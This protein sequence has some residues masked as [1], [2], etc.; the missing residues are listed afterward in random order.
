MRLDG[1]IDSARSKVRE[2]APSAIVGDLA[3]YI[4]IDVREPEEVL[5]GY[6]PD[7]INVPRGVLER[8]VFED[9][10]FADQFQPVLLYS[11]NGVRSLLACLTLQQIGFQN[12]QSLAGGISRWSDEDLPI[13]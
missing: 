6:L 3:E 4:V 1:L 11:E 10:R 2:I 12:V 8:K 7:A 9:P 13:H 5:H